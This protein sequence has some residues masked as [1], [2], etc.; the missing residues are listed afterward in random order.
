M[1]LMNRVPIHVARDLKGH[2]SIVTTAGYL[3][4]F[5]EDKQKQIRKLSFQ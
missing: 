3:K 5:A 4:V 1:L 2:S